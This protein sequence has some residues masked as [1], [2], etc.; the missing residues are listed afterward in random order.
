[1]HVLHEVHTTSKSVYQ[2]LEDVDLILALTWKDVA[3]DELSFGEPLYSH[4]AIIFSSLSAAS[5]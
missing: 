5:R 4:D 2:H 1:M 3:M